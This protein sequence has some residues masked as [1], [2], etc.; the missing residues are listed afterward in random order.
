MSDKK[1]ERS[2]ADWQT[3]GQA[4]FDEREGPMTT[5]R[6]QQSSDRKAADKEGDK[7]AGQKGECDDTH[8]AQAAGSPGGR[9]GT[10][11]YGG[12]KRVQPR[13]QK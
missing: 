10:T 7:P 8:F 4:P 12:V 13:T 5:P 6:P 3:T 9:G 11:P 2:G 1:N